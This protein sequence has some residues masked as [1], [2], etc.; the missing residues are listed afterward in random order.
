M[1]CEQHV[2][3]P[4]DRLRRHVQFLLTDCSEG[5]RVSTSLIDGAVTALSSQHIHGSTK[6]RTSMGHTKW[7]RPKI[8]SGYLL[9]LPADSEVIDVSAEE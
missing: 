3:E 5:F 6:I 2:L 9:S 4:P 1:P 8:R 7:A